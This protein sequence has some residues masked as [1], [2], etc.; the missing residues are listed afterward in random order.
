MVLLAT[1]LYRDRS[2]AATFGC[3]VQTGSAKWSTA[4]VI[5]LIAILRRVSANFGLPQ[6]SVTGRSGRGSWDR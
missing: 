3:C 2:N 1:R 5:D 6:R 4:D